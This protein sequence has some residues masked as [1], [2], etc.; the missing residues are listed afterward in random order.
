MS[1]RTPD[2]V[3]ADIAEALKTNSVDYE[4]PDWEQ[5]SA[6]RDERIAGLWAELA[7][8]VAFAEV[9][10]WAQKSATFASARF[11]ERAVRSRERADRAAERR[12]S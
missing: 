11:E 5:R 2:E 1:S 10:T 8:V 4:A 3:Y 7:D 6:E 12:P 9:P